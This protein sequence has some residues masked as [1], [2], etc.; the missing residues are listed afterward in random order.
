MRRGVSRSR[1]L[2]RRPRNGEW[3]RTRSTQTIGTD[4]RTTEGNNN[5]NHHRHHHHH[6]HH[7]R[8]AHETRTTTR[9]AAK[10]AKA[11][12]AKRAAPTTAATAKRHTEAEQ[13]QAAIERRNAR[14]RETR[15]TP[16]PSRI[17]ACFGKPVA[18][19]KNSRRERQST[20]YAENW[21]DKG[22][23]RN[24]HR[25]TQRKWQNSS[26][27]S[28]WKWHETQDTQ[29]SRHN[30]CWTLCSE[31]RPLQKERGSQNSKPYR[32]HSTTKN[33]QHDFE[34]QNAQPRRRQRKTHCHD[35]PHYHGNLE[36]QPR[37]E[38][39][40]P[41]QQTEE[42]RTSE[43]TRLFGPAF[44]Q[45]SGQRSPRPSATKRDK[46][47]GKHNRKG[48]DQR[49]R[50]HQQTQRDN[51]NGKGKKERHTHTGGE[52]KEGRNED[53]QGKQT[54]NARHN[55]KPNRKTAQPKRQH[56][57]QGCTRETAAP[58]TR[59]QDR[60]GST[61]DTDATTR[62]NTQTAT[63]TRK[64]ERNGST[65]ETDAR[66]KRQ[67]QRHGCNN[68]GQHPNGKPDKEAT[69]KNHRHNGRTTNTDS[70]HQRQGNQQGG[71]TA[72]QPQECN[73]KPHPTHKHN[74][75]S[76]TVQGHH[77]RNP[78]TPRK[79]EDH[80]PRKN[81]EGN[82]FHG[83]EL[84][85][86][87]PVEMVHHTH[88]VWDHSRG[89]RQG[90][91]FRFKRRVVDG[92]CEI[93]RK[94]R[95][96]GA[97]RFSPCD[98]KRS[99]QDHSG[100]PENRKANTTTRNSNAHVGNGIA[101]IR[102][103]AITPSKHKNQSS[104]GNVHSN[105]YRRQGRQGEKTTIHNHGGVPFF[106]SG[107]CSSSN[108]QR[109]PATRLR[110]PRLREDSGRDS[111]RVKMRGS[112]VRTEKSKKR[113]SSTHGRERGRIVNVTNDVGTPFGG[114][115]APLLGLGKICGSKPEETSFSIKTPVV[116]NNFFT[117]NKR[118]ERFNTAIGQPT[119]PHQHQQNQ[120]SWKRCNVKGVELPKLHAPM[121]GIM[122]Q[123]MLAEAGETCPALA[124]LSQSLLYPNQSHRIKRFPPSTLVPKDY[125]LLV[126]N[127]LVEKVIGC[128]TGHFGY[129]FTVHEEAKDRR[130]IVHDALSANFLCKEPAHVEFTPI[131][132]L[133]KVVLRGS[134][135]ATFDLK[136]MYYQI[137]LAK[138]IR[139]HFLIMGCDGNHYQWT[140]LPM[141]FKWSVAIAQQLMCYLTRKIKAQVHIEVYIDNIM[142]VGSELAV[143]AAAKEFI[144]LC[145]TSDITLGEMTPVATHATYRGIHFNFAD[146]SI[147]ISPTFIHKLR[148]RLEVT[149][150]TWADT[151]ALIGSL[152]YGLTVLGL[153]NKAYH[154]LKFLAKNVSTSPVHKATMWAEAQKQFDDCLSD[155]YTNKP[156]H[157]LSPTNHIAVISDAATET[158][159][160][161]GVLVTLNGQIRTVVFTVNSYVSIND[162]EA[163][164]L[165]LTLKHFQT[166]LRDHK[167]AY[168]GDNT[169]VLF[170]LQS[171]HARSFALNLWAGRIIATLHKMRST[172]DSLFYVRSEWNPADAPSRH[173]P[174][175]RK[176][177]LCIS[178]I[179][180]WLRQSEGVE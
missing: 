127:G 104:D 174:L 31:Q 105:L 89:Q 96:D 165:Y 102:R 60:N 134:H 100:K 147:S 3:R 103:T 79:V 40:R 178:D 46:G 161:A 11:A 156:I 129:V 52:K 55:R 125:I 41:E 30:F 168:F 91:I 85:R 115:A 153:L 39:T 106:G 43:S 65:T 101:I 12:T 176:H 144:E 51:R 120:P 80:S 163:Q 148:H 108:D 1:C 107:K 35:E 121:I 116:R 177:I 87:D 49:K 92:L 38:T 71:N 33:Y 164:A 126:A 13:Q 10:T 36:H 6:H 37:T 27:K 157:P 139:K 19:T 45:N 119:I 130:R 9:T 99:H 53:Q 75:T 90:Q 109:A 76:T 122:S 14:P 72:A 17:Q 57:R 152:V 170:A 86:W 32:Q 24:N 77:P 160:G 154:V 175:S 94:Q 162:M 70:T 44:P 142:L 110:L 149:N 73:T 143:T 167:I 83:G 112:A 169:G 61:T 25:D 78:A 29:R 140:R 155:I 28:F 82:N 48:N 8:E 66:D 128:E 135:V 54:R 123:K 166:R 15:S 63:T 21:H 64:H 81:R 69:R 59:M 179:S 47:K 150:G 93:R 95:D 118:E 7:H 26:P 117:A 68:K 50:S 151:R 172:L 2:Q 16:E 159:L 136:A 173:E 133:R 42:N 132:K 74:T 113:S 124:Y 22:A 146:K 180:N 137:P 34:Q 58:P 111:R 5:S 158:G 56:H 141:G 138:A 98:D 20:I 114:Y 88:G 18:G 67:H 131:P 4:P 97:S 171:G 145:N 23:P 84:S 62:V